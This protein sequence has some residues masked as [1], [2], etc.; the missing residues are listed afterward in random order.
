MSESFVIQWKSTV[1]GRVGKGTKIFNRKE[2]EELIEELNS[3]YPEM[4]HELVIAPPGPEDR[5]DD[6]TGPPDTRENSPAG[7]TPTTAPE[8]PQATA[9]HSFP[10]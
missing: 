10:E 9:A 2:G 7:L 8:P 6:R 4:I 3:D 5:D 1:N